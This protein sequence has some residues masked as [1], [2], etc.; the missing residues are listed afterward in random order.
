M[1]GE[2]GGGGDS[3]DGDRRPETGERKIRNPNRAEGEL[4][5]ANIETR[6]EKKEKTKI[7]GLSALVSPR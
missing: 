2:G 7:C 1:Q 5:E 4:S 3:L 6:N